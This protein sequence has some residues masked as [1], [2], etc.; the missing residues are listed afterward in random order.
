[1]VFVKKFSLNEAYHRAVAARFK[2]DAVQNIFLQQM[3]MCYDLT[4][5][6]NFTISHIKR[7]GIEHCDQCESQ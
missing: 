7:E 4:V 2:R 3:I 6:A 5:A 1:M